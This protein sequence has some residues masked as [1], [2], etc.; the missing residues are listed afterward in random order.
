MSRA[1]SLRGWSLRRKLLCSYLLVLIIPMLI[2]SLNTIKASRRSI[3]LNA[4]TALRG[5]VERSEEVFLLKISQLGDMVS[6]CAFENELQIVY[7][8]QYADYFELYSGIQNVL[9]PFF[10]NVFGYCADDM[11][12]LTAYSTTGLKKNSR[13]LD[14]ASAIASELWYEEAMAER[15][16]QWRLRDGELFGTCRIDPVR[17]GMSSEPMGLVY[18]RIR[19]QEFIKNY[20]A[21]SW[22][23]YRLEILDENGVVAQTFHEGGEAFDGGEQML[24]YAYE[25]PQQG[26]TVRYSIPA[27]TVAGQYTGGVLAFDVAL[28]LLS[29]ALLI[30]LIVWMTRSLLRG[31]DQ[32]RDSM[33][34]V[35]GG[36]MDIAVSSASAD[37]IGMLTN[38]FGQM[39]ADIR[40]F[41][42]RE[43]E[44]EKQIGSLEVRALRAQIDPHFLYNV[45]SHINWLALRSDNEEISDIV[46]QLSQFYRTCLN[47]GKEL[48]TVGKEIENIRAYAQIQLLL[49]D[50]SFDVHFDVDPAIL[51]ERMLNFLLQPLVENAIV[52]GVDRKTDGRARVAVRCARQGESILIIV[53]DN[54]P[55]IPPEISR[56]LGGEP[57]ARGYGVTNIAQRI[58]LFY[59]EGYGLRYAEGPQG[60]CSVTVHIARL[61]AA[62]A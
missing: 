62:N 36:N 22:P 51:E 37:E 45:L 33:L 58:R 41:M 38:T 54:G 39:L 42:A 48:I 26:W 56:Q 9:L 47:E 43:K 23:S 52:H 3:M 55:G 40:T 27:D 32:L 8:N 10:E 30:G 34:Q 61:P 46:I 18:C 7:Q 13:Y 35:R 44:A 1:P 5:M 31:I 57:K 19:A 50:G 16:I 29:A 59:G 6:M 2:L 24:L 4:D 12:I 20:M 49:H 15:G 14:S 28:I 53:E 17:F 25:W 60:G 11:D 21:L